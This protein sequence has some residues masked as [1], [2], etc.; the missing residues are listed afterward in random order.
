MYAIS[1]A[2]SIVL[3]LVVVLPFIGFAK[4]T[5]GSRHIRFSKNEGKDFGLVVG[6]SYPMKSENP[7]FTQYATIK[8]MRTSSSNVVWVSFSMTTMVDGKFTEL[9][10]TH[11][12]EAE[13]FFRLY[14]NQPLVTE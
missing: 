10:G 1:I 7:F 6:E 8:D 3:I 9:D 11:S 12:M 4:I 14:G 2:L 5:D 13:A